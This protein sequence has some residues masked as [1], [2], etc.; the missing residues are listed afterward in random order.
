MAVEE[1]KKIATWAPVVGLWDVSTENP[2]YSGPQKRNQPY[3]QPFGI[4]VSD[5]WFQGG[6]AEVT[7]SLPAYDVSGAHPEPSAGILFGYRSVNKEY[8]F[9]TLGGWH[10]NYSLGRFRPEIYS[11]LGNPLVG[12]HENLHPEKQYLLSVHLQ[13]QRVTFEVDGIQVLAHTTETAPPQGQLGLYAWGDGRVEFKEA[14]ITEEAG[15]VFVIMPFK[16]YYLNELF[17]QVITPIVTE[18]GNNLVAHHAG[19]ASGPG[20]II[21]DIE[22]DISESKIVIADITECNRNVYYE[23]GYAHASKIPT[24]LLVQE[25]TDLPFDIGGYRCIFYKN[26]IAGKDRVIKRLRDYIKEILDR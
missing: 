21:K 26:T 3:G 4:C 18:K 17:P 15:R 7:V 22:R 11:W 10:S 5:V 25:D 14:S 20:I 16:D 9:A 19:E 1:K 6:K 8:V 23:V 2:V 24:I 13:G 12:S